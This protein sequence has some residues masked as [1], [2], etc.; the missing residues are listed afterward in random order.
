MTRKEFLE[1]VKKNPNASNKEAALHFGVSRQRI[2]QI[3]EATGTT[4][5][6]GQY[7]PVAGRDSYN[8][9]TFLGQYLAKSNRQ[10]GH[11]RGGTRYAGT[12]AELFVAA[13]LIGN[14]AAVYWPLTPTAI[15]D[16]VCIID[17]ETFRIEVKVGNTAPDVRKRKFDVLARVTTDGEIKYIP[18]PDVDWPIESATH[19]E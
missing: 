19:L 12:L 3:C 16:L 4:L 1:W 17:D 10:T 9:N 5:E 11:I 14:G 15:C 6:R 13:D 2:S 7:P 8:G 18:E